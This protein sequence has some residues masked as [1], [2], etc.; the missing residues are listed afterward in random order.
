[1]LRLR[2]HGTQV[3]SLME[4]VALTPEPEGLILLL[5]SHR[6]HSTIVDRKDCAASPL[7]RQKEGTRPYND[8]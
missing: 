4:S 5:A 7:A 3:C 1:M 8:G 6:V 2:I